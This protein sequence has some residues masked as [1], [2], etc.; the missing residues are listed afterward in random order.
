MAL[1]RDDWLDVARKVDWDFKYVTEKEVFPEVISGTPWLTHDAW[2]G[3]EETYRNTYRE[4]V[5]NQLAKDESILSV[6]DAL[7]KARLTEKLDPG[8][9]SLAKFHNA[10]V[11]LGEYAAC[12]GELRMARFGRDSA[13]RTMANLGALDEIRHTQIPLLL[14][15]DLLRLDSNFNWTHKGYHTNEWGMIAARHLFDDMFTAANAV[16]TAIQLTFVFETGFTNLQFI[17]MAA[18]ADMADDHVFEKALASIQTDESRH[19]QQGHP[20]LRAVIENGGKEW[21]QYLLDKMWWRSWHIF[22]ILTGV[23]MDYLTP[24]EAR[25]HSFKEFMEE[26]IMDQF[27]KNLEEF[28]LDRPWYWDDFVDEMDWLHHSFELGLYTYRQTLW[29]DMPMPGPNER[30]WLSEKYPGWSDSFQPQWEWI[31]NAWKTKGEIATLPYSIPAI[32]NLCHIPCTMRPGTDFRKVPAR[33]W[34]YE[35]RRYLFCSA[36]CKWIFQQQADLYKSHM[37]VVDRLFMGDA[38]TDYNAVLGWMGF[39]TEAEQGHDLYMGNMPWFQ[40]PASA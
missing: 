7:G 24:L 19:A 28:G 15:S 4:Y 27:E 23:S 14:S 40:M 2:K 10:A 8:W 5:Q 17:A 35:G 25:R 3:W 16:D 21:G 39:E 20:V 36:P 22:A 32:C 1:R 38:P 12:I 13:W 37:S 18:M 26:W 9:I 29:F 34:E 30:E 31:E 11:A 6:R 33:T